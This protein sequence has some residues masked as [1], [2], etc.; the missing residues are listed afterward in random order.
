MLASRPSRPTAAS[1]AC[2]RCAASASATRLRTSGSA[3][4]CASVRYGRTWNAWN[5]K[6]MR[7]RRSSVSASSSSAVSSTP[8]RRM[9]PASGRSSP[10]IRLSSVDLPMPDS[11]M[12]ATYSPGGEHEVDAMQHAAAART[13]VGLAQIAQYQH[14]RGRSVGSTG[15]LSLRAASWQAGREAAPHSE[16]EAISVLAAA[17]ILYNRTNPAAASINWIRRTNPNSTA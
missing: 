14:Q 6:P 2:A 12:T 8:S 5:T 16:S 10:A 15:E 4:F 7:S 9:L 3:T 13:G 1:I 11:P 17:A